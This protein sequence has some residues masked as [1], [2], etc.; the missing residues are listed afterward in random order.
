MTAF[1]VQGGAGHRL[2]EIYGYTRQKWGEAQA[3]RYI[4]GLFDKFE[5]I[6]ARGNTGTVYVFPQ[7]LL[8]SPHRNLH[9]L[10]DATQQLDQR[11]DR[12]L[13]RLLVHHI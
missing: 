13:G 3:E 8:S 11:V 12:E 10:P 9:R 6:A 2:D 7:G 5:S 1:R 4:R